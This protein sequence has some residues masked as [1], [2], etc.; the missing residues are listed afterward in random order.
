[1]RKK[2]IIGIQQVI[3]RKWLHQEPDGKHVAGM[4]LS[5]GGTKKTVPVPCQGFVKEWLMEKSFRLTAG[6]QTG[7]INM[8]I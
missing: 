6:I 8:T 3:L 1:M 4:S 5:P 2:S 7:Q